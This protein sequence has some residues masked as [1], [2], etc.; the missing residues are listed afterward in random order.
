MFGAVTACRRGITNVTIT[1]FYSWQTDS[2]SSVNRNFIEDA[3]RRAIKELKADAEVVN[4]MR[5]QDVIL[6]KDT[7]GLS[8]TPP[9]AQAIFDK[10]DDCTVFVPDLTFVAKTFKR[11]AKTLERRFVSNPNVLI[12]YGWALK[13]RSFSAMVPVMNAAFGEP[14]WDTLPFNVRHLR[15]PLTYELAEGD[16]KSEVRKKLVGKLTDAIREVLKNASAETAIS[17]PKFEETQSTFDKA[18]FFQAGERLASSEGMR[19]SSEAI[20]FP[21]TGAKMFLRLVPTVLVD[22]LTA[23]VA[24]NLTTRDHLRLQPFSYPV[25]TGG[26]M[27]DRNS[28]GAIV[29]RDD[30][31]GTV[32][33]HLT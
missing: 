19:W 18:V 24:R 8:G 27:F 20:S 4:S 28:Y 15:W 2:P 7:K 22:S 25:T 9:I 32:I 14:S 12:E 11:V 23:T 17:A 30:G 13:S 16:Q 31:Q 10:I 3:L 1:I 33:K 6:D 29:Y 5:G 21:E 26:E